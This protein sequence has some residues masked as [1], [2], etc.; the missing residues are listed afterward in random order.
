MAEY[1]ERL[2]YEEMAKDAFEIG[3]SF[4]VNG[5]AGRYTE[6]LLKP[7]VTPISSTTDKIVAGAANNVPKIALYY[8]LNSLKL[9]G[10]AAAA[11]GSLGYDVLIRLT[12]HGVNPASIYMNQYRVL[13]PKD[14][15]IS[16][17]SMQPYADWA[18]RQ[19]QFSSM[20]F[21]QSPKIIERQRKYGAMPAMPF[22]QSPK[23]IERQRKYGAMPAMPFEQSPKIIERQRKYGSM[24]EN[25]GFK[26]DAKDT[27]T[28]KMFNMQ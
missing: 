10:A 13:A 15:N 16:H 26:P 4:I 1:R 21:E 5:F 17:Q 12:N 22:E 11:M 9:R 19:K 23:I 3:G 27:S 18:E 14:Q 20:P 28:A 25:L 2:R 7:D 8:I 6:N 24:M